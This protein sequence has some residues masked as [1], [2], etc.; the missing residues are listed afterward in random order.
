MIKFRQ[1]EFGFFSDLFGGKKP[2]DLST[3][4]LYEAYNKSGTKID[5]KVQAEVYNI[6]R[7][8]KASIPGDVWE[9]LTVLKNEFP[10]EARFTNPKT[11][12]VMFGWDE[13]LKHLNRFVRTFRGKPI[14][15]LGMEDDG[16]YIA[17]SPKAGHIWIFE[18]KWGGFSQGLFGFDIDCKKALNFALS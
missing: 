11:K 15:I 7:M 14:L 2:I 4:D 3:K 1:K 16:H 12:D 17:Y 10:G 8:S 5:P 9:Y 13:V 18:I 6:S